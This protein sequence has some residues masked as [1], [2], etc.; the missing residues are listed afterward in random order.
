L[1]QITAT[2]RTQHQ[3]APETGSRKPKAYAPLTLTL[4][5]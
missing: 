3:A 1:L 4:S 2:A 5:T